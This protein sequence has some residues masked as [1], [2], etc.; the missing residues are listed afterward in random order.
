MTMRTLYGLCEA[1][2]GPDS[3]EKVSLERLRGAG[4][5]GQRREALEVA[6]R[7]TSGNVP[8][9][10]AFQHSAPKPHFM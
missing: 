2:S 9:Y 6:S 10:S 4:M 8:I 3:K 5:L 1:D 7:G